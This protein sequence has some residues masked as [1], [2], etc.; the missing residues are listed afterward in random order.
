MLNLTI[1]DFFRPVCKH[2]DQLFVVHTERGV[3][4]EENAWYLNTL[5]GARARKYYILF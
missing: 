1:N 2:V 3:T 5:Q 4:S